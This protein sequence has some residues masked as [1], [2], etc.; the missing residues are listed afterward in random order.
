MRHVLLFATTVL[1]AA[2]PV[3]SQ[4]LTEQRTVRVSGEAEILVI[5]DEAILHLAVETRDPNLQ[6]ATDDNQAAVDAVAAVAMRYGVPAARIQTERIDLRPE[7]TR[8]SRAN[9]MYV[10][11]LYEYQ[12]SR[13]I[14]ISLREL[15]VFDD[16]LRDVIAAGVNH[17]TGIEYRTTSLRLH[18][19]AAR[20]QAVD[21][22]REKAEALA[23]RLGQSLGR[24]LTISEASVGSSFG[25]G[26]VSQNVFSE[27]PAGD[28]VGTSAGQIAIRAGVSIVFELAD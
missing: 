2:L 10:D 11:V 9:G 15:D 16:L 19:D 26:A 21:A 1:L 17:V 22:A 18:R 12:A 27:V 23:G 4:P 28:G 5:P 25:R 20:N 7:Y 3:A 13:S 14:N 8:Q 6:K 24:P